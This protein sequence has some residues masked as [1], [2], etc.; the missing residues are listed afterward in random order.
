[1]LT[2]DLYCVRYMGNVAN[3]QSHEENMQSVDDIR[4]WWVAYPWADLGT[5]GD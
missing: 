4:V 1:M 5:Y 3:L 2:Y